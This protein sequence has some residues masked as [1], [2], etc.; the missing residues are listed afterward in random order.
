MAYQTVVKNNEINKNKNAH[1][2]KAVYYT[3]IIIT[4]YVHMR[5]GVIS[6]E[7]FGLEAKS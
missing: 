5:N 2:C 1:G 7:G 3:L 4:K 6:S